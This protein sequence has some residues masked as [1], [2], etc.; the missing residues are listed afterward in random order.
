[1]VSRF[2][3]TRKSRE[4]LTM[5][6][7]L[8]PLCGFEKFGSVKIHRRSTYMNYFILTLTNH[9]RTAENAEVK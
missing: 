4:G 9:R 3:V 6:V 8:T 5:C 7:Q 1:M 2:L